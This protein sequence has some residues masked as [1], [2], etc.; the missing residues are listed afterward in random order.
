MQGTTKNRIDREMDSCL[1]GSVA[2]VG[3]IVESDVHLVKIENV[4]HKVGTGRRLLVSK[5]SDSV[6]DV[7][8]VNLNFVIGGFKSKTQANAVADA[9]ERSCH[10][11]EKSTF[12]VAF[13][14]EL[15][16]HPTINQ[17][18][19]ETFTIKV[20]PTVIGVGTTRLT[21]MKLPKPKWCKNSYRKKRNR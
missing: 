3:G 5:S 8:G 14:A 4:A 1:R 9:L 7:A 6:K 10:G 19:S 11:G 21:P 17:Q 18:A 2:A 16:K 20:P 15:K 12:A 13:N